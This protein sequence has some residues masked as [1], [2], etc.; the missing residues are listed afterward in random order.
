MPLL[1]RV[2][3]EPSGVGPVIV[4]RAFCVWVSLGSFGAPGFPG[5][6]GVLGVLVCGGVVEVVLPL[7][8]VAPMPPVRVPLLGE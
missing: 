2:E 1:S 4:W 8:W 6:P 7:R 3:G 5:V